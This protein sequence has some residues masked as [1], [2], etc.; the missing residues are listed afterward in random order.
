MPPLF[1]ARLTKETT[2]GVFETTPATGDQF[3]VEITER[4][5]FR[6]MET[7]GISSSRSASDYNLRGRAQTVRYTVG[8]SL[9]TRVYPSQSD[10]LVKW[11]FR[12]TGSP[13]KLPSYSADIF[14]GVNVKRYLGLQVADGTLRS[15]ADPNTAALTLAYTL[16]GTKMVDAI[17]LTVPS[18]IPIPNEPFY[19]HQ[20]A[21]GSV[22]I[23]GSGNVDYSDI[24]IRVQNRLAGGHRA[25]KW[26]TRR[27]YRGRDLDVM[28]N[29][30]TSDNT[31]YNRFRTS[32]PVPLQVGW[33][34][35]VANAIQFDFQAAN[36][37]EAYDRPRDLD[38][39]D[40]DVMTFAAHVDRTTGIDADVVVT[41][42]S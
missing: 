21:E 19:V 4:N 39:I 25:G 36:Y 16:V 35:P 8:G 34:L 2:F 29:P 30:Y 31:F 40:Q 15:G 38:Q 32:V 10:R 26:V 23:N 9:S 14:D 20:D 28:L 37:V 18:P 17:T 13:L 1:Y 11:G 12:P 7:P 24:T 41:V 42:D 33:A 22:I 27:D 5:P 6:V 3:W